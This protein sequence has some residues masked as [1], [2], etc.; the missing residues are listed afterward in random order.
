MIYSLIFGY[1]DLQRG[2]QIHKEFVST[3]I[4]TEIVVLLE[5]VKQL[6]IVDTSK[7]ATKHVYLLFSPY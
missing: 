4:C 6:L 3:T 7:Q 2:L 1:K 5:V